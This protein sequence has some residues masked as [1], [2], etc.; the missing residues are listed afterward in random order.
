MRQFS[1]NDLLVLNDLLSTVNW[2]DQ[3]INVIVECPPGQ[4]Y[5]YYGTFG[6]CSLCPVGKLLKTN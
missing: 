3:Y 5:S 1:V 6:E 2:Y 4:Y